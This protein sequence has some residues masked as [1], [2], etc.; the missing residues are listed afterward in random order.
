MNIQRYLI[1]LVALSLALGCEPDYR[2]TGELYYNGVSCAYCPA[3]AIFKDEA[4]VCKDRDSVFENGVCTKSRDAASSME[5]SDA[6]KAAEGCA[7]YCEFN[8][9]CIAENSVSDGLP[10]VVAGL[11]ASEPAECTSACRETTGGDGSKDEVVLCILD[12]REAAACANEDTQKGLGNA[13]T[14]LGTCCAE[15][16]S[17][18][19]CQDICTALTSNSFL[20]D[21]ID[22]CPK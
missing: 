14:L 18:P 7:E 13:L 11:H 8:R 5:D 15:R 10:E 2:C 6:A 21:M 12:G 1:G 19:L 22:F 20:A 9:V 17:E 4:C 16:A 3:D